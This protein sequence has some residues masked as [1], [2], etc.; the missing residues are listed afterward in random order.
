[1]PN[2]KIHSDKLKLS[3]FVAKLQFAGDFGVMCNRAM[4]VILLIPPLLAGCAESKIDSCLDRGG[5]FNYE[6]CECDFKVNHEYKES[7]SCK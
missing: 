1:M 7:H 5:S 2:K 6:K 3:S 4:R